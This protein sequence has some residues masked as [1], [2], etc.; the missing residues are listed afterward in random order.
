MTN[1]SDALKLRLSELDSALF[2]L[3]TALL[4]GAM[5]RQ[6]D[7]GYHQIVI[8]FESME[9]MTEANKAIDHAIRKRG[10]KA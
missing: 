9:E 4:K 6:T 7:R 1:E 5:S 8:S 10:P 3:R 2:K